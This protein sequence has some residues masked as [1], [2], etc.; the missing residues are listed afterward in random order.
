M[1][2]NP[3]TGLLA[4]CEQA[5]RLIDANDIRRAG[6]LCE[7]LVARY[8]DQA[9]AWAVFGELWARVGEL[10]RAAESLERACELDPGD[11]RHLAQR[12]R[13]EALRGAHGSAMALAESALEGAGDD[14]W[15]LDT[16]GNVFSLVGEQARAL[17]L[18]ERAHAL[19][20]EQPTGIY[21]LATSLRF[22]GRIDEAEALFERLIELRP[23]DHE[24]V[25]SRSVL[26]RQS[27]SSNHIDELRAR[28]SR[29]PPWPAACHYAY[30]L[31]KEYE[32][33]G[34]HEDAFAAF[35]E[36]AGLMHRHR[37]S[38]IAEE[39]AGLVAAMRALEQ[40]PVTKAPGH[41]SEEPVFIIGLPRT[42]STLIERMLGR[43]SQVFAAGELSHFPRLARSALGARDT[44]AA[45]A[46]LSASAWSIDFEALGRD[47]LSATRPRTGR[48]PRFID[49]L[50]RNDLWAGLIHRA[51]PKARFILTRRDPMDAGYA[52]F[53]T[54]FHGG[55]AWTYELS[56]IGRYLKAQQALMQ[57][58]KTSLPDDRWI[59]M[60]YEALVERPEARLRELIEFLGLDW[61]EACLDF[62]RA[63]EA[64][65][66]ASAHQVRQPVYTS[67]VGKWRRVEARLQPLAEALA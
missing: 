65:V 39:L 67:S 14:Y 6:P 21:N 26:R 11:H 8:P 33:L 61:E 7:A 20:P 54:L 42:G 50:P 30:A 4:G 63:P 24:A 1:N 62:H 52:L 3:S 58:I 9:S 15:L 22:H 18:F 38:G 37:A 55:Y 13:Y 44:A 23:D 12:A 64:A 48:T 10:D 66:T 5:R 25:H 46:H 27:E 59:E 41:P 17:E 51:L 53:R 19:A 49:K 56:E 29:C 35:A 45:Y 60:P 2:P 32:D 47:Y 36:G 31:G 16:L 40:Q 34:R 57:A 43:H 28:L